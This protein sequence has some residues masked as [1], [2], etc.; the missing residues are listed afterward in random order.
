M[1]SIGFRVAL[2]KLTLDGKKVIA[3]QC[4]AAGH[5]AQRRCFHFLNQQQ[6]N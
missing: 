2:L 1:T 3:E 4:V 6:M 5:D